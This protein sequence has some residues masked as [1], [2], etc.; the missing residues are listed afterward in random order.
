[1][2]WKFFAYDPEVNSDTARTDLS[3]IDA[4]ADIFVANNYSLAAVLNAMFL[5]EEFY[6]DTTR[7][8]KSP[9]EYVVGSLRML[10]GKLAGST[11][12]AVGQDTLANMGQ[13]LFNPPDVFSWRGNLSWITTQ[14]ML[15][16]YG[17]ATALAANDK[18]RSSELGHNINTYLDVT[19]TTRAAVVDRF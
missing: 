8:V 12:E 15:Q 13:E 3:L 10:H 11:R 5:R 19:A 7:T 14:T 17:F 9:V 18:S 4:L 6:A 16:R 1:K 2:L